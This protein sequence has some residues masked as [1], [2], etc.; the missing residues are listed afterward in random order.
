MGDSHVGRQARLMSQALRKIAGSVKHANCLI[1]FINQIRMK[2]GVMFGSP[3]TTTGGNALKF[4]ASVH[5]DVRRIGAVKQG[6]EVV[7][8]T[9]LFVF[10][11]FPR[12][13]PPVLLPKLLSLDTNN[14]C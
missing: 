10:F 11:L 9:I 14:P 12:T 7:G 2:I 4:Y 8:R 1:V 5:L 13:I 3:D 6:D